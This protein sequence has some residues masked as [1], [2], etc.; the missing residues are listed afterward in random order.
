MKYENLK[1]KY[2]KRFFNCEY[3]YYYYYQFNF[4]K[5]LIAMQIK[6]N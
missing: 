1:A 5:I 2:L 3:Y 4:E 6:S